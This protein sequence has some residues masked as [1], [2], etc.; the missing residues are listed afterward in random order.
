MPSEIKCPKCGHSFNADKQVEAELQQKLQEEYQQKLN[1]SLH[2]VESSKKELEAARLAFE[3]K[4][5]RENEIFTEKLNSEKQKIQSELQEQIRK[6]VSADFENQLK[7]LQQ[8]NVDAEE[9]LKAARAKELDFLKKEQ[10]LKNK[11]AGLDIEVQKKLQKERAD[12]VEQLRQQEA[13]K[14]Q[15][16]ETE[17]QLKYKELEAQLEAQRKLAEEMKRRAE[18]GSMQ[19]QGE[20]QEIVL[21]N[22]LRHAF[23]FDEIEE[24]KKG[25]EGADCIQHVKN[26]FGI[27]CG[28]IIYE[29][30]N[31]KGWNN[32]WIEKLKKDMRSNNADVAIIVT[33]AYP[34]DMEKFGEREGVWICS[35]N[36]VVG[37][38]TIIRKHLIQLHD[39]QKSQ[40]NK[41]DKMQMLYNFL[42]GNEFRGQVESIM[43]G[44]MSIK[45]NIA[46][47]RVQME[48]MWK[49]REKQLEKVL[50]NTSGM[51]GSIK[52]IAG[53][54]V[55][56]IPLLDDT[57]DTHS[58]TD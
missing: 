37:V 13:E 46:R 45:N 4:K 5:K 27:A 42:T 31:T 20:A 48:K 38:C 25:S 8:N 40:E 30:K 34:K 57:D 24:V 53:D 10:E 36:E 47:E 51:Y 43:E 19:L 54:G 52:G 12:L 1:E 41:G 32:E 28:K 44:F 29:S 11:E 23:P 6:S 33:K 35:F 58:L 14:L 56:S 21:E 49:E 16:R 55:G 18:Q 17:F 26:N 15:L 2:D 22:R 50:L 7:L 9:K 3:E 39:V